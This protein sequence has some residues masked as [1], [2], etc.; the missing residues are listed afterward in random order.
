MGNNKK[1]KIEIEELD[2]L[3]QSISDDVEKMVEYNKNKFTS[4]PESEMKYFQYALTNQSL[5]LFIRK[6]KKKFF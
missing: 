3:L 4:K 2:V 5:D 6:H 1:V